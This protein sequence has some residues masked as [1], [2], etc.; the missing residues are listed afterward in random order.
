VKLYLIR[1]GQTDWNLAHRFQGQSDVPLNATGE[2]QAR[3]LAQYFAHR[4][5]AAIYTSDLI[6]ANTTAQAIASPHQLQPQPDARWRE[7]A[8][9]EWE[10]HT[11]TEVQ[12]AWPHVLAEWQ[13]APLHCAPPQGETLTQLAHRVSAALL[14]LQRNHR[15]QT[16]AVVAHGGPLQ[17]LIC[18]ALGLPATQHWQF[19]LA[20]GSL[21]E[22]AFFSAGAILNRLNEHREEK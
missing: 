12:A 2:E 18:L 20:V 16:I 9:G 22:L 21:S 10:G 1:H 5:L 8:F 7:I 19:N 17:V 6:R 14:D 13:N 15:E 11:Y 3:W 4:P